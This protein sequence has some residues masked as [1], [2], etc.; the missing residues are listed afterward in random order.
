LFAIADLPF[1]ESLVLDGQFSEMGGLEGTIRLLSAHPDMTA[2][3]CVSDLMALGAIQGVQWR[4]T[5]LNRYKWG[6][7]G[8]RCSFFLFAE[9]ETYSF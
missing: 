3:F 7:K 4:I 8:Q 1:D 9:F 2:I 5:C 6:K